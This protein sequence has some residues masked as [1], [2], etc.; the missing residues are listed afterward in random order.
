[1]REHLD[2]KAIVVLFS[3]WLPGS[4]ETF[5]SY[6]LSDIANECQKHYEVPGLRKSAKRFARALGQN[7]ALF[8]TYFDS[9]PEATQRDD[10]AGLREAVERL[11]KRVIVLLDELDRM[12]K[13][14]LITLLKVIRGISH[15]PT[16]SFVCAGDFKTIV[17]TVKGN[18]NEE[19]RAYFEK[20]FFDVIDIPQLD[21]A[22]LKKAGIERL[23]ATFNRRKWFEEP[24]NE[25]RFRILH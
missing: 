12:E 1:L 2:D 24:T 14:E 13:E 15:L 4:Q 8:R 5:T 7:V 3:T 19:S 11:P 25:E 10:I 23:I 16:L 18:Y 21:A 17:E 9:L 22:A 20:F 6:L